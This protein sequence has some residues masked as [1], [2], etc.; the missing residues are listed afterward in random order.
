MSSEIGKLI[1]FDTDGKSGN[2]S[3]NDGS[4]GD[5]SSTIRPPERVAPSFE[6]EPIEPGAVRIDSLDSDGGT[7]RTKSGK[8][9]RR[10]LRGKKEVSPA[11]G[12]DGISIKDLLIGIH[13]FGASITGIEELEIDDTE[14]KKLGDAVEELGKIYGKTINPKTAAWVN[15]AA[16]CGVVYGP[17]FVAYRERMKKETAEK[18]SLPRVGPQP[19]PIQRTPPAQA[20]PAKGNEFPTPSQYWSEV[21]E[22]W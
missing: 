22:G 1:N 21:A 5:S 19:A 12:V 16:A 3:D 8:I 14:G 20:P 15:F 17:R 13:A 2:K 6:Y 4:E 9:D 11:V 18:K 7:R 10:T